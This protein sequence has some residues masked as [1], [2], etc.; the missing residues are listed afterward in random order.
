MT[1]L[2]YV[3]RLL[4]DRALEHT[5]SLGIPTPVGQEQPPARAELDTGIATPVQ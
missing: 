4:T 3:S 5:R 2:I 1:E